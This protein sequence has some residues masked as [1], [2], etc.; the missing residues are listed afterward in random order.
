MRS[1]IYRPITPANYAAALRGLA[2]GIER[3][4]WLPADAPSGITLAD[5]AA[6]LELVA[7]EEERSILRARRYRDVARK[8]VAERLAHAARRGELPEPTPAVAPAPQPDPPA[9]VAG[10]ELPDVA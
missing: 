7:L 5:V 3:G 9:L 8:A 6:G 2:D 10:D 4:H 1:K